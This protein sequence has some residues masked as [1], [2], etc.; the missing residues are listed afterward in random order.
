MIKPFAITGALFLI[1]GI[2]GFV[3]P[4]VLMP[5]K[6]DVSSRGGQKVIIE[7]RRIV[8]IPAPMSGCA[9][10]AGGLLIFLG[11]EKKR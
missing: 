2:A 7:T 1:V 5:A 6:T 8:T 11:F 4:R 9:L 3:H 10:L